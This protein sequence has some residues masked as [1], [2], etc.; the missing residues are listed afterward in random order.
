MCFRL[1][2][3]FMVCQWVEYSTD[4]VCLKALQRREKLCFL[5]RAPE[6]LLLIIVNW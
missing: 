4:Y 6:H 1:Y 2:Y 3:C 5:C